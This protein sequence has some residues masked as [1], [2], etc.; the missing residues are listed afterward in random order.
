MRDQERRLRPPKAY[1]ITFTCYGTRLPGDA[2]GWTTR[3]QNVYGT[4]FPE[5]SEP[6]E[7]Y[8]FN[9]MKGPPYK[10]ARLSQI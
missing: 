5:A 8:C 1:F 3:K 4:P 10:L 9:Q 7:F 2:S 6:L